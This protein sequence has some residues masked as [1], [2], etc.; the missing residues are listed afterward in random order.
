MFHTYP[1]WLPSS[2]RY[3]SHDIREFVRYNWRFI[4]DVYTTSRL[5][6]VWEPEGKSATRVRR[7][8]QNGKQGTKLPFS[9][10]FA[11]YMASFSRVYSRP[12]RI[13]STLRKGVVFP[14]LERR[15]NA[16]VLWMLS[17]SGTNKRPEKRLRIVQSWYQIKTKCNVY[18]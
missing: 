13:Y 17:T 6:R 1:R 4:C 7:Y 11:N 16:P 3:T 8:K 9:V 10:L 18:M 15:I 2:S 12:R 5:A 14:L